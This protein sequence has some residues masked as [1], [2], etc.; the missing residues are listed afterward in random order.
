MDALAQ[1]GP[2]LVRLI[3]AG[4]QEN[5]LAET[6]QVHWP[7][8]YGEYHLW[9]GHRLWHAPEA[10]P[11][12]SIPDDIGLNATQLPNGFLL[13]QQVEPGTGIRKSLEVRLDPHR[14]ALTLTHRLH[15][16]GLWPV[17]LSAWA[18]TQLPLGGMV[19]LPQQNALG[20]QSRLLPNRKLVLWPYTRWADPRLILSDDLILLHAAPQPYACKVGYFNHQGWAG[21][22]RGNVFF[23]K[24]FHARPDLAYPDYDCNVETYCQDLFVELETLG[25]LTR[26]EPGAAVTHVE[27][28]EIHTGLSAPAD[29]EAIRALLS[30]I[31]LRP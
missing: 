22:V 29:L 23:L 1:A 25:P 27:E 19:V 31:N 9:G 14:P 10:A 7:T 4:A 12:S 15:N 28:W 20:E 6:P 11:R 30:G 16:E 8:H 2:R 3:L 18:I 5:L 26:L 13:C 17:E 21:Y 24:R